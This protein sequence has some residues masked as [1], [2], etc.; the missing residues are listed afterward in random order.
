MRNANAQRENSMVRVSAL[1]QPPAPHV[2]HAEIGGSGP[3][4]KFVASHL[5]NY[6]CEPNRKENQNSGVL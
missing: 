2:S 5:A 3:T 1:Q 4:P 6:G